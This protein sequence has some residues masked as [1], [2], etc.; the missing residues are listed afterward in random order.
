MYLLIEHWSSAKELTPFALWQYK[1]GIWNDFIKEQP[2][3]VKKLPLIVPMV[4]YNGT[5]PYDKPRNLRK[6]IEGPPELIEEM[7]F[8][9]FHL[10]DTNMIQDE[11]LKEQVW[12]GIVT[13]VFKHSRDRNFRNAFREFCKRSQILIKN[14]GER[15]V[16]LINV[17]LNYQSLVGEWKNPKEMLD[18][19]Q[20]NLIEPKSGEKLMMTLAEYL[21]EIGRKQGESSLLLRLLSRKYGIIPTY[22]RN[23]IEQADADTLLVWGERVLDALTLEE[24]FEEMI[25]A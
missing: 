1:V 5:K 17:L 11:T 6:I 18:I 10:I 22:Y 16:P 4:F 13:F 25:P 7:L 23:K 3:Q 8:K 21:G 14:N 15:A 12:S 2:K 9:D 24:V 20:E 19:A